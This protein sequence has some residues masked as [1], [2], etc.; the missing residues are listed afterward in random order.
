MYTTSKSSSVAKRTRRSSRNNCGN[1]RQDSRTCGLWLRRLPESRRDRRAAPRPS[2]R[3]K[4]KTGNFRGGVHRLR[5]AQSGG[6]VHRLGSGPT[7]GSRVQCE[8][9]RDR[10]LITEALRR[11]RNA[12]AVWQD[13]V[14]DHGFTARY[15]SV[16]R[17]V[18]ICGCGNRTSV[19]RGPVSRGNYPVRKPGAA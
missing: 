3:I 10:E 5:P 11:G 13:L 19:Y 9:V 18:L 4:T 8:R 6:D 14:D 12:M 7:P 16:R 2:E 17:C 1:G 15:A